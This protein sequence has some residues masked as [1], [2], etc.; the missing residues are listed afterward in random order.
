MRYALNE[1]KM[2]KKHLSGK[3]NKN[4]KFLQCNLLGIFIVRRVS[5]IIVW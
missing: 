5:I 4:W 3:I 1:H 2:I